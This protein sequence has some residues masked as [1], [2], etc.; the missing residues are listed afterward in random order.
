[1]C[2]SVFSIVVPKTAQAAGKEDYCLSRKDTAVSH[3]LSTAV[4]HFDI[5]A[6]WLDYEYKWQNIPFALE[7]M[8]KPPDP[9]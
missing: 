1:M 5:A 3:N 7:I 6:D 4:S 2:L 8:G 9:D